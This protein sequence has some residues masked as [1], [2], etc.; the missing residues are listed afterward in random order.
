MLPILE[1]H[2]VP[3]FYRYIKVDKTKKFPTEFAKGIIR[4]LFDLQ[5]HLPLPTPKLP[6]VQ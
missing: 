6:C 3:F 1:I 5:E 4:L 2:G